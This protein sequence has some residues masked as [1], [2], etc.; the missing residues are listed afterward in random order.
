[1]TPQPGELAGRSIAP[2][3]NEEGDIW[4]AQRTAA[5]QAG[6]IRDVRLTASLRIGADARLGLATMLDEVAGTRGALI[7]G[8][9][10]DQG[11]HQAELVSAMQGQ[12]VY[13]Y[14]STAPQSTPTELQEAYAGC[15]AQGVDVIVAVGGGS[16]LG[17]AKC[18]AQAIAEPRYF[19]GFALDEV[20]LC[21]SRARVPIIAMPTTAGSGSEMNGFGAVTDPRT[22]QKVRVAAY[23]LTPRVAVLDPVLTVSLRREETVATGA[24]A[25]SHC[26]EAVYS[27][28]SHPIS[29]AMAMEAAE[30]LANALPRCVEKPDD[31]EA[32]Q[33]Q[34]LA[35][36]MSSLAFANS[37]LGLNSAFGHSLGIVAGLPIALGNLI[38]LP[39]SLSYNAAHAPGEISKVGRRMKLGT[40]D[41]AS[42]PES[43]R[44]VADRVGTWLDAISGG[45][46][47]RDHLPDRGV[48]AAV[49]HHMLDDVCLP[50]NPGPPLSYGTLVALLERAW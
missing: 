41:T 8:R 13:T 23:W 27:R 47:L 24:N 35:S 29:T 17:L 1:V 16:V 28:A 15:L 14:V 42:D 22:E 32:R 37:M 2:Q 40:G 4:A 7:C 18:V 50:F 49:A 34:L 36:S 48:I 20:A 44:A 31:L 39:I 10:F 3:M 9:H 21:S 30:L 46:R 33:N 43:A 5:A 12:H 6:S 38:M 45:Q 25:L 26:F 11:E 19:A